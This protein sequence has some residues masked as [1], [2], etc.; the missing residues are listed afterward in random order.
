[1][2]GLKKP[3]PKP[4]KQKGPGRPRGNDRDALNGIWFVL[5]TGWQ[6][7]AVKREWFNVSNSTLHDRFQKWTKAGWLFSNSLAQTSSST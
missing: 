6:W 3:F 2:A 4:P 7:K 5:W 1:M